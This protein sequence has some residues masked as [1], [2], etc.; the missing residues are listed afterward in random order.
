MRKKV[1]L[2]RFG[3]VGLA[4]LPGEALPEVGFAVKKMLD[5]PYSWVLN[6]ANDEL[7]YLLPENFWQDPRYRCEC[8]MSPGSGVTP[9]ILEKLKELQSR[10]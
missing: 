2:A 6:L 9:L 5:M 8:S 10:V 7:G 3:P 4:T 1:N